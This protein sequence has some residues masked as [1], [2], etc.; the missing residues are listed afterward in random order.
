MIL[1][2][3]NLAVSDVQK[4]REF[5][6]KYFGLDPKGLPG[7]DKIAILRD[8]QGMALTLSNFE[9]ATEVVYPGAF[10]IGFMQ[11]GPAKVDEINQRLKDDGFEVDPPRRMHG[12]WTFY[13]KAPGG[14][15]IEVLS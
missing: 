15:L 5:L 4:A 6:I 11:E 2:H 7:N 13:F 3:V 12:S 9:G 8:E 14:F 10:H 1:N